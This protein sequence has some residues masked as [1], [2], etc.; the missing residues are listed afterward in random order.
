MTLVLSPSKSFTAS[1]VFAVAVLS[2]LFKD[3]VHKRVNRNYQ[4]INLA[5]IKIG[6]GVIGNGGYDSYKMKSYRDLVD[7]Q[8]ILMSNA[9]LI[10]DAFGRNLIWSLKKLQPLVVGDRTYKKLNKMEERFSFHDEVTENIFDLV[11]ERFFTLLDQYTLR[12]D[13]PNRHTTVWAIIETF[14]PSFHEGLSSDEEYDEAFN[15]ALKMAKN[16]LLREI[17]CA[18]A[19]IY[20]QMLLAEAFEKYKISKNEE[21]ILVL[22]MFFPFIKLLFQMGLDVKFDYV[23]YPTWDNKWRAQAIPN[24]PG[25]TGTPKIRLPDHWCGMTGSQLISLSR[26]LDLEFVT[27]KGDILGSKTKEAAIEA[28]RRSIELHHLERKKVV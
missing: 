6:L 3:I 2:L 16:V 9:S 15:H 12:N 8:Q 23:V 14:N 19:L 26:I 10:W 1:N 21:R 13:D 24:V 11:H 28:A 22:D 4:E 7:G 20:S 17:E 25:K 5:D 18:K 27:P